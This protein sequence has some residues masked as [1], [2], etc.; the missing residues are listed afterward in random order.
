M[1]ESQEHH[2]QNNGLDLFYRIWDPPRGYQRV[3]LGVH[4]TGGYG[5]GDL[6][7]LAEYC[8][9]RG[10]KVYAPD[11]RGFG[12]S[13]GGPGDVAHYRQYVDDI[14]AFYEMIRQKEGGKPVELLGYSL[15]AMLALDYAIQYPSDIK[16][17]VACSPPLEIVVPGPQWKYFGARHFGFISWPKFYNELNA[18]YIVSGTQAQEA[19][20]RDPLRYRRVSPRF[21]KQL[22]NLGDDLLHQ[23]AQLKVPVL[24]VHGTKDQVASYQ[25]AQEFFSGL[26]SLKDEQKAFHSYENYR[27]NLLVEND[28]PKGLDC[29]K[30]FADIVAFLTR[31]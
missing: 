11:L 16:A 13:A 5:E 21:C 7:F 19:Y 3:L 1:P 25:R 6:G 12:R 24:M 15:G 30:V 14:K 9:Q 28:P 31:Y 8:A 23:S 22:M 29:A 4:G 17:V 18:E 26:S 2:Y 20:R 10:F 27:H